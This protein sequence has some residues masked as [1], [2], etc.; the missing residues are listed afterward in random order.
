M[1]VTP[2]QRHQESGPGGD[3][4][5]ERLI[6]AF[7]MYGRQTITEILRH[8][9][10]TQWQV[11]SGDCLL[12]LGGILPE[13][14]LL[15]AGGQASCGLETESRK[16]GCPRQVRLAKSLPGLL[17]LSLYAKKLTIMEHKVMEC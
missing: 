5:P 1:A 9:Q 16:E 2:Q 10:V 13:C 12:G 8:I 6:H 14:F 4:P 17:L 7:D 15:V 11:S 3:E